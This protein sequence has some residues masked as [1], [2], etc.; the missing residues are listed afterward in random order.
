MLATAP[1]ELIEGQAFGRR[2]LVFGGGVIATL[3]ITTLKHNVVPRHKILIS[4]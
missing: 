2:L 1:A 4:I 3:T